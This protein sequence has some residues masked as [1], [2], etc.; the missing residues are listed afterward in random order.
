MSRIC[1]LCCCGKISAF[2]EDSVK[3]SQLVA[4]IYQAVGLMDPRINPSLV[5]YTCCPRLQLLASS[6][7]PL[8]NA[9]AYPWQVMP[10]DFLPPELLQHDG[11][12]DATVDRTESLRLPAFEVEPGTTRGDSP[13]TVARSAS[14]P[15]LHATHMGMQFHN[16]ERG[17]MRQSRDLHAMHDESHPHYERHQELADEGYDLSDSESRE[18][19]VK[20]FFDGL[21]KFDADVVPLKV[22]KVGAKF[23]EEN[24][25]CSCYHTSAI[26]AP[27]R[28]ACPLLFG[29]PKRRGIVGQPLW[30][31][32]RQAKLRGWCAPLRWEAV[33]A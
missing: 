16:A 11:N 28:L 26:V 8:L 15:Q 17:S 25:E 27:T 5:R 22:R 13:N 14:A 18:A 23:A 31:K 32:R 9:G 21:P 33:L 12:D 1:G 3:C 30:R 7:T 4:N 19:S 10:V 6:E 2:R 24:G 29:Q 20:A